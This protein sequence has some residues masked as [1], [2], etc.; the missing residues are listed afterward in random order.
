[1]WVLPIT[2]GASDFDTKTET[3]FFY[4]GERIILRVLSRNHSR[5]IL[6]EVNQSDKPCS[7]K[8]LLSESS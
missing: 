7:R 4:V 3:Q 1:M 6:V 2:D 8:S 5:M